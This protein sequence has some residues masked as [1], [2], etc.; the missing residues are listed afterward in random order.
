MRVV[1]RSRQPV[2]VQGQTGYADFWSGDEAR[3]R[4]E[5]SG[6]PG[7]VFESVT[8]VDLNDASRF[9]PAQRTKALAALDAA[10][11]AAG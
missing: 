1:Y 7:R 8:D 9:G 4:L 2:T 3:A 11:P 6:A 10:Y 5:A